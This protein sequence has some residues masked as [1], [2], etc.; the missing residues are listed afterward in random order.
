MLHPSF[1]Y[2]G[3]FYPDT[4]AEADSRL[5]VATV[6]YDQRVRVW[7]LS[8]NGDGKC[9]AEMCVSEMNIMEKSE[10]SGKYTQN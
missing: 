2:G 5:I 7:L 10:Q 9:D 4:A 1:V 3:A 6:C 8:M